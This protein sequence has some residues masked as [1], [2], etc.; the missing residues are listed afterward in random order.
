MQ[1]NLNF[2][3]I[4]LLKQK[5]GS[6]AEANYYRRNKDCDGDRTKRENNRPCG[7]HKQT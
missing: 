6:Y 4:G 5:S 1:L 7:A 2:D 3:I